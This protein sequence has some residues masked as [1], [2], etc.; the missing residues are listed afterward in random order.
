MES[1]KSRLSWL[2]K[3]LFFIYLMG[4]L[5]FVFKNNPYLYSTETLKS[6]FHKKQSDEIHPVPQVKVGDLKAGDL[7][8][9]F[10]W[11]MNQNRSAFYNPATTFN[12]K[13]EKIWSRHLL[14]DGDAIFKS[15]LWVF[16]ESGYYL[17]GSGA[18][19]AATDT[20]GLL[21]WKLKLSDPNSTFAAQPLITKTR[22]FALTTDGRLFAIDKDHGRVLWTVRAGVG[23]RGSPVLVGQRVLFFATEETADLNKVNKLFAAYAETGNIERLGTDDV[24]PIT[25][26]PPTINEELKSLYVASEAGNLFAFNYETGKLLFKTS[27]SDKILSAVVLADKKAIFSTMDGKLVAVDAKTGT[28]AWETD[29]ESPSDSTPTFIPDYNYLAVMTNNGY[30]QTIDIK[31]GE[32]K[33]KFLTH[34]SSS[35]HNTVAIRL[36]GRWIEEH[37][38]K[39]QYKG[40]VIVAPCGDNR[41]CIYNPERGQIVDRMSLEGRLASEIMISGTDFVVSIT[42]K[43]KDSGEEVMQLI[44]LGEKRPGSDKTTPPPSSGVPPGT[45][46]SS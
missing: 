41:L 19:L 30:L 18:A 17:Y 37:S 31:T 4:C 2:S 33:W 23:S 24:G 12:Y 3:P 21:R 43:D 1:D 15:S 39:W 36:K 27:T 28:L 35:H 11:R 13:Y 42:T 14:L 16:D 46:G 40:W 6:M 5:F 8:S 10:V 25:N 32:R 20:S 26:Y 22:V 7:T 9:A 45:P 38:M 44:L 29:L 34:N